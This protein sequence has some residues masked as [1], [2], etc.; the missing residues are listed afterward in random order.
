MYRYEFV[1]RRG[2]T[3]VSPAATPITGYTPEEHYADPDLGL[4]IVH[5]ED[6]P[7]LEQYFAGG[8]TFYQPL[9]L[10]WV[11]KDGGIVWTEQRN[12]P[13]Y[14]EA[15]RL[16]ALEGIARD[17]TERV[18]RERELVAMAMIARAVA[19]MAE[20]QAL[21][22]RVL[23][24]ALHAVPAAEKGS[25]SLVDAQGRLRI[26]ATGGYTDPALI[27]LSFPPEGG[28]AAWAVRER[29]PLRIPEVRSDPRFR[30]NGEVEEARTVQ[31]A[32]VAPLLLQDRAI[33]AIALDNCSRTDAFTE[34][35]LQVLTDLASA[36]ALVVENAR[37]FEETRRRAAQQTALN[38]IL[39]A[40][41]R[42]GEDVQ[43]LVE[44]ALDHLLQ[45][46][47]LCKGAIWVYPQPRTR[48][49]AAVRGFPE[50]LNA[51]MS[52]LAREGVLRLD[53][54][55]VWEDLRAPQE[56]VEELL[57]RHSVRSAVVA[58]L[59]PEKGR[60]GGIAVADARP[61][62][63]SEDEVAVVEMLGRQL[64]TLV[65]RA[66]SIRETR[67]RLAA[68]EAIHRVSAALR[69]AVTV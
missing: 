56:P 39:V 58:P 44:V 37:L 26:R 30:Y 47:G 12:V 14:D 51:E 16:V 67:R 65:E 45:A 5:P 28:Y 23:D 52:R 25:I 42:A 43:A 66:L 46:L 59:L 62:A 55:R 13:I 22:E 17:V 24:A 34:R 15:G 63:W 6:R 61:R 53:G 41:S 29:C 38:A 48:V 36:V 60:V 35:D 3:Y 7:R 49:E 31:S 1:P 4:K 21:L 32:I 19:E 57:L 50:T 10:R 2:F 68:L 40:A 18:L 27:W 11:R 64:G 20:P 8:G 54:V 9:T 69:G 33:G